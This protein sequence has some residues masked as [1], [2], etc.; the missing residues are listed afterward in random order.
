MTTYGIL[1]SLSLITLGAVIGAGIWQLVSVR[2][3][4]RR[5]GETS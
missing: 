3:S 2:A 5:R 4:Q 1:S